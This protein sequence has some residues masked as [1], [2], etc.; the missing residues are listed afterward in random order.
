MK[1]LFFIA[2]IMIASFAVSAQGGAGIRG[3]KIGVGG[4]LAIPL[5]NLNSTSI[6]AGFDLLGQYG[7]ADNIAITGDAGYTSLFGKDGFEDLSIIPIRAGLRFFPAPAFYLGGKVGVGI[8]KTKGA[9]SRSATAYSIGAGYFLSPMIDVSAAYDGYS[10][11]GSFGLVNI[12]L[13]YTF[14]N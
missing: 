8:L 9:D 14:G 6:G 13:G 5:S 11:S 7:I 1:K 4:N 2:T 3:F 12:R 10:K